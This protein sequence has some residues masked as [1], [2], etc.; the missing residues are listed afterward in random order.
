MIHEWLDRVRPVIDAELQRRVPAGDDRLARAVRY[1]ALGAGK[2]LR[3]AMVLA[4]CDAVGGTH[5][6]ALPAAA[7]LELLHAYTLVHDDLPALDDDDLRRGRKTVHKEFD[8]ATAILT[9]DALLTAAFGALAD[10]GDR[11]AAAVELLARRAGAAEL[12]QGQMSD[13]AMQSGEKTPSFADLEQMH[14]HK[15]GA[16]FAAAAE[17]GVIAAGADDGAAADADER[18]AFARYG[19]AVGIA[20]QFA[21]DRDD[22]DFPET[23]EPR[24]ARAAALLDEAIGIVNQYGERA[25]PLAEL[26][27]WIG[28]RV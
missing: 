4:A 20:F 5:E 21:D 28:A 22:G 6:Q 24:R 15:T 9:G 8:E 14:A 26:A 27:K 10:L 17:L 1:A 3:P 13:L 25:E 12:I 23:A 7:G 19:M 18:D 11:A 16:L 2:R